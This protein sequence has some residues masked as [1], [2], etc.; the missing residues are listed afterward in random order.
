MIAVDTNIL[1]YAHRRESPLHESAKALVGALA[2]RDGAWA[3]PWPCCYEFMGIVTNRRIW[4]EAAS[5]PDRAW[6]Q[7]RAWAESPSCRLLAETE[8]E[9]F[10]DLLQRLVTRPRVR[11]PLVH[12]ARVAAICLAHGTDIL[13]TR[14]RDFA[15]FPEL[16]ARDPWRMDP[17]GSTD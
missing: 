7:L 6:A 12:D 16:T 5:P 9:E 10:L 4:H 1:V 2:E 13:L 11:G 17:G 14:D 15:L 8:T 3:I